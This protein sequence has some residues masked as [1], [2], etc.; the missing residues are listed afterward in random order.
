M[1]CEI[2]IMKRQL[3][4]HYRVCLLGCACATIISN[5]LSI[6]RY[7][8]SLGLL[9]ERHFHWPCVVVVAC[10]LPVVAQQTGA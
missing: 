3:L 7:K 6:D 4:M 9:A 5:T 10:Y 8:I 2:M 1:A